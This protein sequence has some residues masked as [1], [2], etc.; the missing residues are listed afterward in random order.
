MGSDCFG[1][2]FFNMFYV[3]EINQVGNSSKIG[4]AKLNQSDLCSV[5]KVFRLK[6]VFVENGLNTN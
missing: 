4:F 1:L 3:H 5:Q 6:E 2:I